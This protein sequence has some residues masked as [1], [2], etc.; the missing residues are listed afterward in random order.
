MNIEALNQI[1][2]NEINEKEEGRA[3]S[4]LDA[5]IELLYRKPGNKR[6][7]TIFQNIE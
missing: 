6:K 2:Y 5:N 1:G 7:R 3:L 4:K